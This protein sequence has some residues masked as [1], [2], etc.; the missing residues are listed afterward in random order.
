MFSNSIFSTGTSER[1]TPQDADF[2]ETTQSLLPKTHLEDET[3]WSDSTDKPA[4]DD[5]QSVAKY[6]TNNNDSQAINPLRFP[7]IETELTDLKPAFRTPS[8]VKIKSL[9]WLTCPVSHS[10]EDVELPPIA[11]YSEPEATED[12]ELVVHTNGEGQAQ[13]T[14]QLIVPLRSQGPKRPSVAT[15]ADIRIKRAGLYVFEV[16]SVRDTEISIVA[17]RATH[18]APVIAR[19][20]SATDVSLP[21]ELGMGNLQTWGI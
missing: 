4:R 12:L 20:S 5:I 2:A 9:S 10:D 11:V 3:G 21:E 18:I 19:H 17:D 8:D 14:G 6:L 7:V 13:V 1:V 15:F 16:R